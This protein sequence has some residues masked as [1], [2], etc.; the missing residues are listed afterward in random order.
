MIDGSL[1]SAS[2]FISGDPRRDAESP[3]TTKIGG[4]LLAKLKSVLHDAPCIDLF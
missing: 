3:K 4:E 1:T 2:I